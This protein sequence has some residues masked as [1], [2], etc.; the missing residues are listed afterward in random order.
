[1]P[2]R[3]RLSSAAAASRQAKRARL[4]LPEPDSGLPFSPAGPDSEFQDPMRQSLLEEIEA[5]LKLEH[6]SDYTVPV[7]VWAALWLSDIENLRVFKTQHPP[8]LNASLRI[9]NLAQELL[10][11][12]NQRKRSRSTTS[13]PARTPNPSTGRS[14]RPSR[15]AS[16][17]HE[18]I[19]SVIERL[20]NLSTSEPRLR[21]SDR[22]KNLCK[23]RDNTRC[24]VTH[25]PEIV[26]VAHIYPYP[27]S[28]LPRNDSFWG[29]LQVFWSEERIK[30]WKAAVFTERSTKACYNLITFDP[31]VH[32]CWGRA[33]F[34]LKPL[35]VA[36]DQ[37]SMQVQFFWLRNYPRRPAQSITSRPELPAS[38]DGNLADLCL[39]DCITDK[40]IVSGTVLTLH[41]DDPETK[42]LPSI[43]L[44][45]MQWFLHRLT[46]MSGAANVFSKRRRLEM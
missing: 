33:L 35:D 46:A 36:E 27:M 6:G 14:A 40:V 38:L 17:L 26:E 28:S 12:W 16:S 29:S 13:S 22:E 32:A 5:I 44:L 15:I 20:K 31:L 42:P 10:K 11:S 23:S 25:M 21:R 24:V 7:E 1:M 8:L 39:F 18:H 34:A 19:P 43:A 30:Q 2:P 4:A 9:Q 45:E 41:T 3:K 37:K